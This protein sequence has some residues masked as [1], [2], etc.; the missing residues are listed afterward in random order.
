MRCQVHGRD[1]NGVNLSH[2][3]R[4]VEGFTTRKWF[5][6]LTCHLGPKPAM[7]KRRAIQQ[8]DMLNR[9]SANALVR[10][11]HNRKASLGRA[12][13]IWKKNLR[14]L[15]VRAYCC[16]LLCLNSIDLS[17]QQD[18]F[19]EHAP[20]SSPNSYHAAA[21]VLNSLSL[22]LMYVQSVTF[23]IGGSFL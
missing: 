19:N 13:N 8:H 14:N 15:R 2:N 9:A 20:R 4:T 18:V 1:P 22:V 12:R 16:Q 23:S 10:A 17:L 11:K 7:Y 21:S 6:L 3:C 5:S